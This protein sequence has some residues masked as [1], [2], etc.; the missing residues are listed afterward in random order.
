M[1]KALYYD[2]PD[3]TEFDAT[4]LEMHPRERGDGSEIVLDR[5]CF[6]PEGGGQ[7]ADHGEIGGLRVVHTRSEGDTIR[8]VVDGSPAEDLKG[9]AVRCRI[10][11]ARRRDYRQQH[12][13]QHILSG[14]LMQVGDY[15]TVSVHQ[16]AEYTTIEVAAGSIPEA[17]L[18]EVERR[19]NDVIE[20]DVPV[21]AHWVTNETIGDY[22]LRRP[23]K[24]SGSIRII[25]VGD[26]DCVACGGIHVNRTGEI[27]LVRLF[28]VETIRGNVRIA[29]KIGD[30]ALEHYRLSSTIVSRL[31]AD[32]SAQPHEV[33][34]RIALL[35][36]RLKATE[37]ETRRLSERIH[38]LVARDLIAGAL[39]AGTR[40]ITAA[41]EDE[42]GDFLR[43]VIEHL[44]QEPGTRAALVNTRGSRLQWSIGVAPDAALEVEPIRTQLLGIIAAKGGGR[45]PI[46]QGAGDRPEA[47]GEFLEQFARLAR[48]Q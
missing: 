10:D 1:T 30:R 9:T 21:L 45:A 19:A 6:Y 41:F 48:L 46:W 28:S 36:E 44:V 22:P 15:P 27:R 39:E 35:D 12:T 16:G 29:W 4:V 38:R 25:Q 20:A 26:Y 13:G 3:L 32:L 23:P 7:P 42:P 43:G 34:S 11:A 31:V 14:A 47:A 33:V 2:D 8:H 37:Q 24:V 5:S 17:D 18:A 40:V